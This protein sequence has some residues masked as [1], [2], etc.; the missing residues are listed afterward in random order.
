M[1][2]HTSEMVERSGDDVTF[3]THEWAS[4][5]PPVRCHEKP[6]TDKYLRDEG[7]EMSTHA[8]REVT[9]GYS[10][11]LEWIGDPEPEEP[12]D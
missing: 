12:V 8:V 9:C 2:R 10:A 5:L 1:H 7:S 6:D 3:R 11:G 4:S